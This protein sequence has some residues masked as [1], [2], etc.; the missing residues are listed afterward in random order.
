[1]SEEFWVAFFL[2]ILAGAGTTVGGLFVLFWPNKSEQ[3]LG[4]LQGF[5]AGVMLY[6]SFG[7]LLRSSMNAAGF[8]PASLSFFAGALIFAG[9]ASLIPE[10][11]LIKFNKETASMD[12]KSRGYWRS[13]LVTFL[14]MSCHNFPE[15]FVLFLSTHRDMQLGVY[16]AFAI[17]LHN[18][19]EGITGI[20]FFIFFER[21]FTIL[22]FFSFLGCAT[23]VS[24]NAKQMDW[25]QAGNDQRDI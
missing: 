1:M 6:L 15:G 4:K 18:I 25:N 23:S 13:A 17:I 24:S 8:W 22:F 12:L 11:D 5:S 3:S 16:I 19:P 7:D 2:A 14:G 9:V 10:P 20:F 21:K